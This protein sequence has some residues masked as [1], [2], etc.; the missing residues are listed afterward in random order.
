MSLYNALYRRPGTSRDGSDWSHSDLVRIWIKAAPI[1]GY[2]PAVY[3]HD[4]CGKPM[5]FDQHGDTTAAYGWE[6]DHIVPVAHGGS[7]ALNN[8]RALHWKTNRAKADNYDPLWACP[9]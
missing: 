9:V 4:V 7:D 3:R 2:D 1:P 5:R 6:V 8:L